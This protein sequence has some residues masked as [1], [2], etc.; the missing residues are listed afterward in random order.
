MLPDLWSG[1]ELAVSPAG[2][3]GAPRFARVV[4]RTTAPSAPE[5]FAPHEAACTFII[6]VSLKALNEK[7][8]AR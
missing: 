7:A 4:H 6:G 2:S 8:I 1:R 3:V 5:A